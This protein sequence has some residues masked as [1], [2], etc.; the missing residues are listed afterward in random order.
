MAS[1]LYTFLAPVYTS[2]GNLKQIENPSSDERVIEAVGLAYSLVKDF[3][4]RPLYSQAYTKQRYFGTSRIL[5]LRDIPVSS[6]VKVVEYLEAS[7]EGSELTLNSDCYLIGNALVFPA[8]TDEEQNELVE[9]DYIGGYATADLDKALLS[10][11]VMQAVAI[12][13]AK[14]YMGLE[15]LGSSSSGGMAQTPQTGGVGLLDSVK[16]ML[17]TFKYYGN[18]E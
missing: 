8:Y 2:L 15:T 17:N 3:C 13:H 18:C 6:V 4:R 7:N 12:Y 14:E 16:E 1:A 5:H 11:L 9:V 10:A